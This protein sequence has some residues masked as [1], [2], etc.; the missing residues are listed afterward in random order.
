MPEITEERIKEIIREEL[1]NLIKSDRFTFEKLIQIL[2]GRNIK[3]G[4][5]TGTQLADGNTQKLGFWGTTPAGQP[6]AVAD[7]TADTTSLANQLNALLARLRTIGII[8][9]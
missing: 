3:L 6:G 7:A 4:T 9:T 1:G 2:D 5:G 8:D